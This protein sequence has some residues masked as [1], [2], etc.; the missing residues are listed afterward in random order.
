MIDFDLL[1]N[2]GERD[3]NEDSVGM[4]ENNGEYCFV[5]ADGLG[6]HGFGEVA[7]GLAVKTIL[8]SFV[9]KG[10]NG[11]FLGEAIQKAQNHVLEKQTQNR[12][13]CDM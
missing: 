10:L 5:V 6:G 4:I 9:E 13:F 2:Q 8:E 1:T 7:S 3:N 12:D 11:D